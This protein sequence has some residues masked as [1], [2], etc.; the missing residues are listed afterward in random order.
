[1][2][3]LLQPCQNCGK[4]DTYHK[5]WICAADR[6]VDVAHNREYFWVYLRS[7]FIR[8]FSRLL[9]QQQTQRIIV[10]P[11]VTGL[12]HRCLIHSLDPPPPPKKKKKKKK[13]NLKNFFLF[14]NENIFKNNTQKNF[15]DFLYVEHRQGDS[16]PLP[17]FDPS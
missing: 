1:M 17:N 14:L 2:C 6:S 3:Y 13:K 10:G 15:Y 7:R 5:L 16:L 4:L 9:V 11:L 8:R 12:A